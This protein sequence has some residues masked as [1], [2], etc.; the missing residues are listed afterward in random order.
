MA[1]GGWGGVGEGELVIRKRRIEVRKAPEKETA[2][3]SH[4]LLNLHFLPGSF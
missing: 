2:K 3:F 4:D 1:V